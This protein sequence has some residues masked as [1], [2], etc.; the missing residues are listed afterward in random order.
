MTRLVVIDPQPLVR[1]MVCL[2]LRRQPGW[3]VVGDGAGEDDAFLLC[4]TLRPDVLITETAPIQGDGLRM[5]Q[6]LKKAAPALRLVV[7]T[8]RRN[9]FMLGDVFKAEPHGVVSKLDPLE[10]LMRAIGR[11]R[12]GGVYFSPTIAAAV[13]EI[14]SLRDHCRLTRREREIVVL[15]AQG[16]S[17]REIAVRLA[18]RRATVDGH[19][20]NLMRKLGAR[21]VQHVIRA[22]AS[23]GLISYE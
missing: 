13:R 15:I 14:T 22:A 3:E 17:T 16:R 12:E 5:L 6:R 4:R 9:L 1:E 8:G 7:L 21:H 23:L 2:A 18:L 10:E 20:R 11:V 19:R